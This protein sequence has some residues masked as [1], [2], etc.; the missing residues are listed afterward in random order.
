MT[1]LVRYFIYYV[2]IYYYNFY[3]CKY[4]SIYAMF[5]YVFVPTHPEFLSS[6]V[7]WERMRLALTPNFVLSYIKAQVPG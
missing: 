6:K 5:V 7:D 3:V 4:L 1:G 2:S